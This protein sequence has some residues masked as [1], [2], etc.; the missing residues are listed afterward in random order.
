[1]ATEASYLT[2]LSGARIGEVC[3]ALVLIVTTLT[4]AFL[5]GWKLALVA[6]IF[7]PLLMASGIFQHSQ[8]LRKNI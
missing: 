6:L 7:T 5:N 3:E 1:M 8:C 4:I 2:C